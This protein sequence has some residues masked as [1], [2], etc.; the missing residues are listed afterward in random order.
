[1]GNDVYGIEDKAYLRKFID[2]RVM[3]PILTAPDLPMIQ[4]RLKGKIPDDI[5]GLMPIFG[6]YPERRGAGKYALN[7]GGRGLIISDSEKHYRL[8]GTDLDGS[9][10][11]SVASSPVNKIADVRNAAIAVQASEDPII[12]C[13]GENMYQ[14]GGFHEK[15]F[16]LFTSDSVENEKRA[17]DILAEGYDK[18]GW[19]APYIQI[20]H[21]EYE[22]IRWNGQRLNTLVFQLPS[23]ESDMRL[24]ELSRDAFLHLKFASPEQIEEHLIE[25]SKLTAKLISWKGHIG[26]L[27]HQGNLGPTIESHLPQNFVLS[28]IDDNNLGMGSVDHTS[29][30]FDRNQCMHYLSVF[31]REFMLPANTL[32][33][34]AIAQDM[35]LK[36]MELDEN[37]YTGYFDWAYKSHTLDL[38]MF[39]DV[40]N[41]LF[42]GM[43]NVYADTRNGGSPIPIDIEGFVKLIEMTRS[44]EYDFNKQERCNPSIMELMI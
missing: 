6:M 33:S 37:R 34:L 29:T 11:C 35:I 43:Q 9:M 7:S 23:V 21:V 20:G 44:V 1:M 2:Y 18:D 3:L 4:G 41:P 31:D 25:W 38:A 40:L 5:S 14:M 16:S 12:A 28:Q 15:P 13:V 22:N 36:G 32:I 27:I 8:K 30:S 17:S 24:E 39:G 26:H 42:A 19:M 10:S